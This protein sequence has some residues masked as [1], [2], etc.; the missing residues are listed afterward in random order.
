MCEGANWHTDKKGKR[1]VKTKE[2]QTGRDK[3]EQ[4]NKKDSIRQKNRDI[5]SGM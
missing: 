1:H 2:G 4:K 3:E 5:G